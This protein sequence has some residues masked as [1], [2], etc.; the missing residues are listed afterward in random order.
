MACV[1]TCFGPLDDPRA[2]NAKHRLGDLLV[3]MVAASL[4]GAV[5]ATEFALFARTR[6]SVLSRLISYECAP[7]HDTFSRL[8]RVLKPDM[9]AV[10]FASFAQGFA[11]A[12]VESGHVAGPDIVAVD[13]K[14]LR[15][16]YEKGRMASP[17]LT[18]RAF[19]ADT[20]LCLA[21][22]AP[23]VGDNEVETAL[24]VVEMIDLAGKIVTADALHCHHRMAETIVE[25]GGDY[26]LTLKGNRRHWL[27][28]A[29]AAFAQ[30]D[31]F[32]PA[33]CAHETSGLAHGR[34]EWRKAEVIT[35]EPLMMGHAAFIRIT[36][37]RD[38][39]A[40]ATRLFMSSKV[41][42]PHEAL[43]I[44]RAH[45]QIENGLHWMLDVHLGEDLS[46][47]RKDHAPANTAIINTIARNC[48]QMADHPKVPISHRIKKCA[49]DD[50][51]LINAITHMR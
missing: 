4:C 27:K 51:Y 19:A 21:M 7:S 31:A 46:R 33:V 13:G 8:L 20:R 12:L 50:D 22:A 9:F 38:A 18:V 34:R 1:E 15:R 43:M 23:G 41:L 2:G 36:S 47:A 17:P 10:V 42:N 48:L 28:K 35:A 37:S 24:K 40:P 29:S 39:A 30:V 26:V 5:N 49:W 25:R 11:K 14:V 45:W 6:K 3:M 32:G 44:T 16:A